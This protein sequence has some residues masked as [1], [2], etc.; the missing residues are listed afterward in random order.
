MVFLSLW[1]KGRIVSWWGTC[2]S[3]NLLRL[4]RSIRV[5][6]RICHSMPCHSIP[7]LYIPFHC[8]SLHSTAFHFIPFH[9]IS[10]HCISLHWNSGCSFHSI[11]LHSIGCWGMFLLIGYYLYRVDWSWTFWLL[12]I[13]YRSLWICEFY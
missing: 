2:R 12:T 13:L 8:I 9:F 1:F 3:S 6:Q 7:F 11:P 4:R 5:T 10:F